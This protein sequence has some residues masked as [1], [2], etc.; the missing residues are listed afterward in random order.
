MHLK[1]PLAYLAGY[2]EKVWKANAPFHLHGLLPIPTH[3]PFAM[4]VG[5]LRL[6][7]ILNR[8]LWLVLPNALD[9]YTSDE[10]TGVPCFHN[11]PQSVWVK[12][13][14]YHYRVVI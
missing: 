4:Y 10:N 7:S 9:A 3:H 6:R 1:A 8:M 5:T 11:V 2:S 12:V 13:H 14:A